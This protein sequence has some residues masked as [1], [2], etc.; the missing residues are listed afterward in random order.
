VI[1]K[2]ASD[3]P[4]ET[5]TLDVQKPKSGWI[6]LFDIIGIPRLFIPTTFVFGDITLEAEADDASGIEK[7]EFFIDG[8]VIGVATESP[9]ICLWNESENIFLTYSLKIRACNNYGGTSKEEQIVRR[10]L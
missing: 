1:I 2:I 4:M 6:Y 9:Y 10:L 5:P 8:R 7:V 3:K